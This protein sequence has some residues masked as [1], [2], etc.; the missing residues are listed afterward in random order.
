MNAMKQIILTLILTA[1]GSASLAAQGAGWLDLSQRLNGRETVAAFSD[2]A[3]VSASSVLTVHA[4]GERNPIALATLIEPGFA[5]TKGSELEAHTE[6][7]VRDARR[8]LQE[9]VIVGYDEVADIAL[10][11]VKT[12]AAPV[13]QASCE[14]ILGQWTIAPTPRVDRVRVGLISA[15]SRTIESRGGTLGV[16]LGE[17]PEGEEGAGRALIVEVVPDRAAA[18]AGMEKG[19]R[20]LRAGNREIIDREDLTEWLGSSNPGTTA[21]FVVERDGETVELEVTLDSPSDFL[22]MFDRNQQMSGRTSRRKDPFPRVL[23]TDIPLPPSAMGGAL[24]NL[25]GEAWGITISRSDRV[26]TLALPMDEVLA[27]VERIREES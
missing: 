10:L 7:E 25:A 23:Q 5:V 4:A 26:T 24:L 1:A 8:R 2:S 14:P 17:V 15:N 16:I 3:S 22:D 19:D 13:I 12:E 6:I 9:A 21:A 27:A 18:N 11:A 20:I